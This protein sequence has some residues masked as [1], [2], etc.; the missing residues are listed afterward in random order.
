M[1]EAVRSAYPNRLQSRNSYFFNSL[2]DNNECH[3]SDISLAEG[4][5]N[6]VIM[7]KK[8][9]VPVKINIIGRKRFGFF[10]KTAFLFTTKKIVTNQIIKHNTINNMYI[11][12]G[13]IVI[14]TGEVYC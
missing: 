10:S 14:H 5:K 13:F 4:L 12:I 11:F 7:I 2:E 8:M 1:L 6:P 3:K 9:L